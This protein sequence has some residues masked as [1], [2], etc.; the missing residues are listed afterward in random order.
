MATLPKGVLKIT[1]FPPAGIVRRAISVL[2]MAIWSNLSVI[3]QLGFHLKKPHMGEATVK[4]W[5]CMHVGSVYLIFWGLVLT[6]VALG[7]R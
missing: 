5:S 1:P 3:D 6:Y 2:R 4:G 7:G